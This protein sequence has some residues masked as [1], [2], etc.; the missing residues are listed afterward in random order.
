M[1]IGSVSDQTGLGIHTIRYYEKQ[2]LI[3]KP[4]KDESGHR[5][6]TL[7]DIDV[8]DWVSCMKNSGMSLNKIKEYTKAFYADDRSTCATL[9]EEHL[10]HLFAQREKT[11]HYIEVTKNKIIRFKSA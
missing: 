9:L 4:E 11:D 3:K 10:K 5:A 6:Y 8:L 2:G 7:K 1:K